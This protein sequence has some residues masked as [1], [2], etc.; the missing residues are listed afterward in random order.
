MKENV[1]NQACIKIYANEGFK[2]FI[3]QDTEGVDTE[4]IGFRVSVLSES[5]KS[6]LSAGITVGNCLKVLGLKLDRL[7][8]E[9]CNGIYFFNTLPDNCQIALL[10][11]GYQIG[12]RGVQGYHDCLRALEIQDYKTASEEILNSK[13][14]RQTPN[15]AKHIAD[16]IWVDNEK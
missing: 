2:N 12:C 14:A 8:N 1:I 6:I 3:Y 9:L 4:G 11:L 10:D 7:Y 13:E 5:E 15:R 16:L